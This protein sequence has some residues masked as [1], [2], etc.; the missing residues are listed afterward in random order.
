M[1]E[2]PKRENKTIENR[3]DCYSAGERSL[4]IWYQE[5]RQRWLHSLLVQMERVGVRPGHLTL[6]SLFTGSLFVPLVYFV[7]WAA[8]VALALHLIIDGVDGPL[9]RH[10][11]TASPAGSFTDTMCDQLVLVAVTLAMM[12]HPEKYIGVLPGTIYIFLYT[13][14][15]VFAMVRNAMGIPYSWMVRPRFIVYLW[16]ALEIY[17]FW[18]TSLQGSINVLIWIIN[19][20]LA[21]KLTCGFFK[22]REN[23]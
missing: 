22:I 15:V 4:M 21:I 2:N 14:L 16:M 17:W 23:L 7:P 13:M 1:N 20:M 5:L 3:I 19:G 10:A 11:G 8:F 12:C 9:A 6:I 18:D